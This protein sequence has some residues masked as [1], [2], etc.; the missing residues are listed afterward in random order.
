MIV[1]QDGSQGIERADLG[2]FFVGWSDPPSPEAH[3]RLLR[4]SGVTVV[5]RE[6]RRVVGFATAITDGVLSAYI[7]LLEVLPSHQRRGIGERLMHRVLERLDG[8]Y[9]VDTCCDESLAPFY[10]RF[11]MQRGVA[12]TRRSYPDQ[13]G[14]R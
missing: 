12:M 6:A 8:I 4:E 14:R 3:L 1:L 7:P 11:G 9:I 13:S 10:E 5:A 2:G